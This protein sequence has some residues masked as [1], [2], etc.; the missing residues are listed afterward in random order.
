MVESISLDP[1]LFHCHFHLPM[2][3]CILLEK[4]MANVSLQYSH[5]IGVEEMPSSEFRVC[6]KSVIRLFDLTY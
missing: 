6:L 5:Y 1:L 2:V 3:Y 4:T